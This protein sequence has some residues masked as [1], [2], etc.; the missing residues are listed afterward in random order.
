MQ[1]YSGHREHAATERACILGKA[2]CLTNLK[3]LSTKC[4]CRS[5]DG[6]FMFCKRSWKKWIAIF[7]V[8]GRVYCAALQRYRGD[9]DP[10][11]GS[12]LFLFIE[13]PLHLTCS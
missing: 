1:I 6:I 3:E 7:P 10:L 9:V 11:S 4:Q 2:V 5:H 13:L 12:W 8:A